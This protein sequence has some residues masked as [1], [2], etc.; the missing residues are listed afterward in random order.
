MMDRIMQIVLA[1]GLPTT[2]KMQAGWD[3][4]LITRDYMNWRAV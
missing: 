2:G 3:L 4:A 1:K